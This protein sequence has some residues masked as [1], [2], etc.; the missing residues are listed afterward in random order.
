ML[1]SLLGKPGW[2]A[3]IPPVKA[4]AEDLDSCRPHDEGSLGAARWGR[5]EEVQPAHRRAQ[6]TQSRRLV[7][8]CSQR[9]LQSQQRPESRPLA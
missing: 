5:R 6:E 9:F 8:R 2:S 4:Q 3:L 7:T 1:G